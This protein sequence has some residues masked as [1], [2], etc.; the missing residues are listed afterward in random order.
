MLILQPEGGL[1]VGRGRLRAGSRFISSRL[2]A[3][4]PGRRA[5]GGSGRAAAPEALGSPPNGEQIMSKLALR[6]RPLAAALVPALPPCAGIA[7]L[8]LLLS[9]A[10]AA[11]AQAGQAP[12]PQGGAGG[13]ALPAPAAHQLTG[14]GPPLGPGR[15]GDEV[16]FI[17]AGDSRPTARGAPVP[18][19][20]D[21]ILSEIA[22][23]HPD[24][25]LWTGDTV[26][27][28]CDTEDELRRELAS[29][30]AAARRTGVPLFNAPGNHEI[31]VDEGTCY[32]QVPGGPA[33]CKGP[34]AE[35]LYADA[36]GPLF[37]SF[38]YAGAHF[39]AIDAET[40][41]AKVPDDQMSWLQ[42]DLEQ[43]APRPVFV[44]GHTEMISSPLI[45]D[46]QRETHKPIANHEQLHDLFRKHSV[47]VVFSG[48]EHLYWRESAIDHD[49]IDYFVAGGAGA[50]FYAQ[51]QN[52]GFSHYL[53]VKLAGGRITYRVIEPGR[54]YYQEDESGR[55]WLVNANDADIPI[56]GAELT[57]PQ[58]PGDCHGYGFAGERRDWQ[59]IPHAV[60]IA[61]ARCWSQA[62]LSH[63]VLSL[64]SP[65]GSSVLLTL[66]P[67]G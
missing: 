37:G 14:I 4:P 5:F 8:M 24:F 57:V 16:T 2:P 63:F 50:P 43:A 54:L 15:A 47:K 32:G 34:C 65:K 30:V 27:G 23:I 20:L 35:K 66:R 19:V 36:F 40:D 21:A 33:S 1:V 49:G 13:A 28:Y 6:E 10:Q 39:V 64:T 55:H 44:F 25:V 53:L 61:V 38:D 26:Y 48:H 59:S 18:R 29:F 45:D 17:V 42:A 62:G 12:P 67:P 46:N 51:P 31:H 22:V 52:G 58:V 56:R 3:L 60:E 9:G 7:A 41:G 11:L